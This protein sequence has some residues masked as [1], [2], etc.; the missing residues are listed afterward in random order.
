MLK[1]T[2]QKWKFKFASFKLKRKYKKS[3]KIRL[4]ILEWC[5]HKINKV[6]VPTNET[7][8]E[9]LK[10]FLSLYDVTIK[11]INNDVD[12]YRNYICK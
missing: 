10:Q 12:K 11:D 9:M 5:L 6:D 1:K 8:N 2:I 7:D 4:E 3:V